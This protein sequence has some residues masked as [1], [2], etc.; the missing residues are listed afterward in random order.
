MSNSEARKCLQCGAPLDAMATTCKYC[1]AEV[2]LQPQYA[3]PQAPNY[4]QQ[5]PPQYAQQPAPQ[6]I[7][8]Q[9]PQYGQQPAPQYIPPQAPQ[10]APGQVPPMYNP[11]MNS[12]S[13]V[14]A[15]LLA[16]FLGGL[17]IHKFYLGKIWMGILY[18]LFCWTYIPS[19]IGLIEGII[20]LTA[21]DEKFYYKYVRK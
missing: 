11:N 6:Y 12:K 5:Q 15:G 10:Y 7:P 9:A 3:Q 21:S 18:I 14:V 8:P 16:I 2:P 4:A 13:K 19:L 1:G 17:G 20:Y